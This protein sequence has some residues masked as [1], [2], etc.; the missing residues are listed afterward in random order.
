MI[1]IALA[2]EPPDFYQKVEAKGEKWLQN[3]KENKAPYPYW[4]AANDDLYARYRG[5]CAY[6]GTW[7]CKAGMGLDHFLPKSKY[8]AL[9]YKWSNYRLTSSSLN[10]KKGD[11]EDILDPFD[12]PDEAFHINLFSG[13]VS[14]NEAAFTTPEQLQRA[15][16]TLAMLPM[17]HVSETHRKC[18]DEF[19][20]GRIDRIKLCTESP[21]LYAEML[22]QGVLTS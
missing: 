8:R 21:F 20:L 9:A 18:L 22:R 12:V 3:H 19:I 11:K 1:R 6:T 17:G 15:K 5:I 14:I 2:P 4:K 7:I 16:K 13:V 10:S